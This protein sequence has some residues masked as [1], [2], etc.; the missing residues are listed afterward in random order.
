MCCMCL[1]QKETTCYRGF[2]QVTS[3]RETYIE[4]NVRLVCV[5]HF[6]QSETSQTGKYLL[7]FS[8]LF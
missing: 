1:Q 3:F 4:I 6:Y 8:R 5:R 7:V 2:D